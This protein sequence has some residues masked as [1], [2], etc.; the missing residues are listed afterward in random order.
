MFAV[1]IVL[2]GLMALLGTLQYRWLGQ[3]SEAERA[4]LRGSLSTGA[5][6]FAMDI[7]R[8]LTR[9]HLLFQ[10]EPGPDE[11][12]S[13]RLADRLVQWQA[14]SRFPRLLKEV[15]VLGHESPESPRLRRFDPAERRLQPSEWPE[16]MSGW[17]HQF[18]ERD[19]SHSSSP[20]GTVVITR[21]SQPIWEEVPAIVVPMPA[22]LFLFNDRPTAAKLS[23]M[24]SYVIVVL[25]LDYVRSELLPALVERHFRRGEAG[26]DFHVAVVRAAD[27]GGLVYSSTPAFAPD[28]AG[29]SDA[30][31][32]L[33]QV[34]TQD[35]A[36]MVAEVR[37]FTTFTAAVHTMKV[38][39]GAAG[40]SGRRD[41]PP[42][43]GNTVTFREARP[44]SIL[45]QPNGAPAG[46]AA[47]G[48]GAPRAA[49]PGARW[50]L[51]LEHQ[52]GSL[53][54]AIGRLRRRNLIISSTI[55]GVL[56]ASMAL[57][58][59][60]TRRAHHLARQQME[61]V[62]AVSHEL[63]TPLAVIRSAADNLADGVIGEGEQV[64]KYGEL[65]QAEGRRLSEMVEQIL[66]LAGIQSGG[67]GFSLRAVAIEPLLREIVSSCAA[68]AD[69]A[70][71]EVEL[72][73][74]ED[75]PGV[76]GDEAALRRAFAN[77]VGNALKYGASGRWIGISATRDRGQV[78]VTVADRGM[79]IPPAEQAHVFEPFY[80]AADA[81]A[82]RIQGAGL[83]LSLVQRIV[84][85]HGGRVSVK[86][87]PGQ[88]SEF[89]VILPA[90]G[91]APIR[92]PVD[93]TQP[94][95][96]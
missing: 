69:R 57:L 92:R 89:T 74:P 18:G 84:E 27:G 80:R 82:A 24:F 28:G 43:P 14:T 51:V 6:E 72:T 46:T 58:V 37:R 65:M 25:D 5:S 17:Q 36:T 59:L 29:K 78:R 13:R 96:S 91:D 86:S 93:A 21:M 66:E 2:A 32:D 23:S 42:V 85:A 39:R 47:A 73:M 10:T 53:E 15:Y 87:E 61:F 9:A 79:G 7:D 83:G 52:A 88:G 38:T 41:Q 54:A 44:L 12:I 55:L 22:P 48:D 33:F 56:T 67:R 81:V 71:M 45:L 30:T 63:R 16:S 4:R 49:G 90:S 95:S 64:R 94:A 31:A 77:L 11:E 76:L 1:A 8:E 75:L 3:I 26:F 35:F 60:S 68:L 19:V 34:R 40:G 50:K 20:A 62:A 70:G